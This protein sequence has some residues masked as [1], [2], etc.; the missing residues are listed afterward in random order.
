MQLRDYQQDLY[1]QIK[2]SWGWLH[3][4]LAVA[5]TGSGK[6]ILFAR[7]IA[8]EPAPCVAIA[9]RQELVSQ[10][11]IALS[12]FGVRHRIVGPHAIIKMI[13]QQH[14]DLLGCS[15]YDPNATKAVAGVD[16][17]VR[18]AE[19]L[20]A[21]CASVR[22]WVQD[23]AHHLLTSNKWGRATAMFPNARGLGVT[24][25]PERADGKGLGRHADGVF[26]QVVTGPGMRQLIQ[27]GFLTDY[28]IF[29][30]PS[31]LDLRDVKISARTGDFNPNDL[32]RSVHRS[33]IV[34]DIVEHYLRLAPG[35][36]G[37]TFTV[38]VETAGIISQAY[39]AAGVPAEVV[40]AKT[41]DRSRNEIL[42]RF[43]RGELKQLVN[44]DLFGEGFDA[45]AVEVVS[46][47]RPTESY[48]VY[49]QQF[50]R[51]LRILDGKERAIIIDHVGNVIRHGLPD[52]PRAMSLNRRERKRTGEPDPGVIP[53][54]AC[55]QC[56][57]VYERIYNACPYCGH[58]YTPALRNGP[59]FVDGDLC[60]LDA[61]TL[62]AM[63]GEVERIDEHPDTVLHRMQ[64]A[65]AP[66]GAAFGAAK[67][68]RLRQEAQ[69]DLRHTIALWAGVQRHMGRPDSESYRRFYHGFGVDVLTAQ[70]LGRPAAVELTERIRR[71]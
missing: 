62:A 36:L 41:P 9:H 18:R 6:T 29:A 45:P 30:P 68:H 42:R 51:A 15:Y 66:A 13:V 39:N 55:V 5:P 2:E 67:Q 37:L 35:L 53:V 34:G 63:R 58:I 61:A 31:D 28:R 14:T 16:T 3:N 21:W 57:G 26:D 23:E 25:T 38:D 65:G 70:A 43:R 69:T 49:A 40:S 17:L 52:A 24:A 64:R 1:T 7:V 71:L 46:Q 56:A 20:A 27:E 8:D 19:S 59:E 11:S 4:V 47:G 44:V 32:R 12:I 33:H 60:E 10:I 22:L 50:G 48:P 54:T